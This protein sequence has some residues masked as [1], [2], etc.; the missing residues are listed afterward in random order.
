MKINEFLLEFESRSLLYHSVPKGSIIEQILSSGFIQPKEPFE[1]DEE[2]TG[3]ADPV[4][5][6]SRNQ[7]LRFPSTSRSVAQFVI[8]RDALKKSGYKVIPKIGAMMGHKQE[9]EERVYKPIPVKPPYI[10]EIQVDPNLKI[11]QRIYDKAEEL[12]VPIKPWKQINPINKS[13]PKPK[14][15]PVSSETDYPFTNTMMLY[16]SRKNSNYYHIKYDDYVLV[17][18]IPTQEEAVKLYYMFLH[19]IENRLPVDDLITNPEKYVPRKP[20]KL[21]KNWEKG[22]HSVW[23]NDTDY[24]LY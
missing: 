22:E 23:P 14:P 18:N 20:P 10:V 13:T 4:I 9:T 19:R 1:A 11:P 16:S 12:G 24:D 8:D 15:K 7:Y 5:S 17:D 6:L 21:T 3:E 2:L